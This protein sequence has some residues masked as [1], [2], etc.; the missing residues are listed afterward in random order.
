MHKPVQFA[1]QQYPKA[2]VD[3]NYSL[4]WNRLPFPKIN[5]YFLNL[6]DN[7]LQIILVAFIN[8]VE[9]F[10]MYLKSLKSIKLLFTIFGQDKND[11][12]I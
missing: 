10:K 8:F 12:Q 5:Y 2:S 11:E 4:I 9:K 1:V 3:G 6:S 7:T